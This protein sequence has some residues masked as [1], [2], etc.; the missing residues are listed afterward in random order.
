MSTRVKLLF[1]ALVI[2]AAEVV[3]IPIGLTIKAEAESYRKR[4]E[5]RAEFD[6][7]H[8]DGICWVDGCNEKQISGTGRYCY[9]H[10]CNLNS[11][12]ERVQ[13]YGRCSFHRPTSDFQRVLDE[14]KQCKRPGCYSIRQSNSNYCYDH[15]D[16]SVF[17][18]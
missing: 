10:T 12:N 16:L 13:A 9:T 1:L 2:L 4:M 11:C 18:P 17:D 15:R 7:T 8:P 5:W 6:R 14:E 3:L